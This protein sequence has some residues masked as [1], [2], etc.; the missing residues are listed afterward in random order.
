[1]PD[2]HQDVRWPPNSHVPMKIN[3]GC[4]T[5]CHVV[6]KMP[7]AHQKKGWVLTK[8]WCSPK[9]MLGGQQDAR[10]HPKCWVP[11]NR[12]AGLAQR[13]QVATQKPCVHQLKSGCLSRCQVGTKRNAGCPPRCQ[14]ATEKMQRAQQD[15]TWAAKEMPAA[16]QKKS[17]VHSKIHVATKTPH[18]H[19]N[20]RWVPSKQNARCPPKE[21]V[22]TN[23]DARWPTK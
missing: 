6:T 12:N 8:C 15:D 14:V 17:C 21:T 7:H 2:A 3:T 5:R 11:T 23:Q 13:G 16:H 10:W 18:A 19:K 1:M 4:P 9:Y 22:S 20:K